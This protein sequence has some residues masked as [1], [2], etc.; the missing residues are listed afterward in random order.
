MQIS[1]VS[2]NLL[3]LVIVLSLLSPAIEAQQPTYLY[4]DC[5][6]TTTFTVNS[7][8]QANRN[9]VLSSLSSNSTRG[10]GFYNTTAGRSPDMVYGLFLC[11]G[12]LSTSVCQ[13][14]V[15]F[16][17]TDIS[18]RC[19]NQTTAVVWYDE[20]LLRYSNGNIFSVVAGGPT[21]I[22]R[23]SQNVTDNQ[24]LFNQQVL[25]MMNDT[26]NQ[27]A[28]TPEGAKKFATRE[29]DV[30]FS[31]TFEAL[32]TLGQCTPDL[33][34]MDCNR[35]LR[36][37]ISSL[38]TEWRGAR[39]LNPSCNVRYETYLF[40]NQTGVASP[41][42]PPAP[43]GNGR[44]SWPI[45]VAIVV[46]ITA[47][48]FLLLLMCWLLKRRAK[49]KYDT[50]VGYDITTIDSLQY[51]YA[52]IEAA[53]D[54]FSDANKL[55]EGG[56]GEVYK[57][58][59]SNQQEIAVK[60][61][62]RGSG[63]GDEEFKNEVVLVAKL[64][65]RSLVRLLGFCLEREERILVYEYAPNKSLDYFVFDPVKQGQ[66]DWLRR[67]KII[68]GIARGIL[69]LHEDSR[70]RIIHRDLKASNILLDGDM[71]P[72]ISD[73]G[74][75]RIFGVDQT[76][77]T[78]RRVVGTYGYMSPEYAMQ[79]QFSV[80]SDAYSFEVLVLEIVSGQRN[81]DFYETEGAQDLISYAWKL[82]KDGRS[83]ELL[84]PVLRDNYSRN[85]VIRC[86]HSG[87]YAFKKIQLTGQQWP[88]L[89]SCSTVTL[90][91]YKC[92]N[93]QHLCFRVEQMGGCQTRV[94]NLINLLVDQCHGLTMRYLQRNYTLSNV[95]Y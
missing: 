76:Q 77:G 17:T 46:P 9:T 38:P 64:Q 53:T 94:L 20:C 69:Y 48:I 44:R 71:N 33:I 83:L 60:K 27:A 32:Y 58:I 56:F 42:S 23:S 63:Q 16:A 7:T 34:S 59:L 18:Q 35:C 54:K 62:S 88:R 61:L 95:S 52:T 82:W 25:A 11:R 8:Y 85:E 50:N 12:D 57:G 80:K 72:K 2:T 79:G 84:D 65:H 75:A 1:T 47:S 92:L 31:S 70:L 90:P 30:N 3:L 26:A 68:E 37:V 13:A 41:P 14:C 73:F 45:I 4:H 91:H 40:Y 89:F 24:D 21:F 15:T 66:L 87:Y 29:E 22:L 36:M 81:S 6:N 74:M 39:V 49:K 19:P 67:Y 86:I 93:N 55:G 10:D 51:D 78:T 5:P 28:N 43:G